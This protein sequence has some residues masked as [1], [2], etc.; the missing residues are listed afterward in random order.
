METIEYKEGG[1]VKK[2]SSDDITKTITDKSGVGKTKSKNSY[3][4]KAKKSSGWFSGELSF[5]NW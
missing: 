2:G 3:T 1:S 5:L 4:P